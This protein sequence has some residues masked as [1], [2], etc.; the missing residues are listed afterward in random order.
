MKKRKRMRAS[1]W[2]YQGEFLVELGDLATSCQI[3]ERRWYLLENSIKNSFMNLKEL[4]TVKTSLRDYDWELQFFT[5]IRHAT[6]RVLSPDPQ[7]GPEGYP[8]MLLTTYGETDETFDKVVHWCADRGIGAVLN[9]TDEGEDYLFTY[10]MLWNYKY[11]GEFYSEWVHERENTAVAEK[12]VVRQITSSY[13]PEIPRKIFRE[14][15]MQQ[16]IVRPKVCVFSQS[17][18]ADPELAISLA[19]I[20]NPPAQEHTQIL[21][22]FSWFFP[23]HYGLVL[24][25]EEEIG[26]SYFEDV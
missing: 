18:E 10:G 12:M 2:E 25:S 3:V 5:Q 19:S 4:L 15:L 1:V 8:Y 23:R 20:G 21:E 16:G 11:R 24:V 22:A 17:P 26:S 6:I 13:W 7:S 14:F 9:P